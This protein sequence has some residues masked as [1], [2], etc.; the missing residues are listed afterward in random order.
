MLRRFLCVSALALVACQPQQRASADAP[1]AAK[2]EIVSSRPVE[3]SDLFANGGSFHDSG[4]PFWQVVVD[5]SGIELNGA[6][7]P[8]PPAMVTL[9]P[10]KSR[11]SGAT[12]TWTTEASGHKIRV[13]AVLERCV[14][15]DGFVF[16]QRVTVEI[17]VRVLVTC[18]NRGSDPQPT[19]E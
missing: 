14:R 5:R 2:V 9:P 8:T 15:P 13:Q 10:V 16:R 7:S 17:G 18:G 19:K 6:A 3:A 12:E 4:K 1:G 11:V